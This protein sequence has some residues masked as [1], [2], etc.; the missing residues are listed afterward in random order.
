MA[1]KYARYCA[2]G[3]LS[4]DAVLT[5][6]SSLTKGLEGFEIARSAQTE[7][8]ILLDTLDWSF[9][10][11]G[12]LLEVHMSSAQSKCSLVLS[13]RRQSSFQG[14]TNMTV[15]PLSESKRCLDL[16]SV[17]PPTLRERVSLLAG[18][19]AIITLASI[20]VETAELIHRDPNGRVDAKVEIIYNADS[21]EA[22]VTVL[23]DA[24]FDTVFVT[25]DQWF[26]SRIRNLWEVEP[27][28][29]YFATSLANVRRKRGDYSTKS[30]ISPRVKESLAT[31]LV[32]FLARSW[33]ALNLAYEITKL[34]CDDESLHDLR[35]VLR[36]TRAVL[37]PVVASYPGGI[38][39][40]LLDSTKA[41]AA[42]T[43]TARDTD[44]IVAY[45]LS[46]SDDVDLGVFLKHYQAEVREN[47]ELAIAQN[48]LGLEHLWKSAI[49]YLVA[50]A[51]GLYKK[52]TQ[53]N[54]LSQETTADFIKTAT[55]NQKD[56]C[57]L[58]VSEL[59]NKSDPP[60]EELHE[61]RKDFK[62][63]R[64]LLESFD[65]SRS[66]TEVR[67]IAS[68]KEL[69]TH[70]GLFQDAE[71]RLEFLDILEKEVNGRVSSSTIRK[72]RKSALKERVATQNRA[73]LALKE[74]AKLSGWAAFAKKSR[75]P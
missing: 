49:A 51:H 39:K 30:S 72:L 42:L 5:K 65:I 7:T 1:R 71:V 36:T 59:A 58:K 56:R 47:L 34:K 28:Y 10:N 69:Q 23:T 35:V 50:S 26:K 33:E 70:L 14:T 64:Y 60:A 18:Q 62:R 6:A 27:T 53:Q 17:D 75:K 67:D 19:R 57:R 15:A 55:T 38:L 31:S 41:L 8:R 13:N 45:L 21:E 20:E 44:V 46:R 68:S 29:D 37:E 32:N 66:E 73:T 43:N 40:E 63:L 74:L 3:K 4:L 12:W 9:D 52:T 61:L 24:V 11:A 2:T 54:P 48:Y 22:W 16:I 25:A